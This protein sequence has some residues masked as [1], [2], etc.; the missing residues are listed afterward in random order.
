ML[1]MTCRHSHYDIGIRSTN[2]LLGHFYVIAFS[3]ESMDANPI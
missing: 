1:R 2:L 3:F